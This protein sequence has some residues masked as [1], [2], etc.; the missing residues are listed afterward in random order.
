MGKAL[1]E[2][3]D[4]DFPKLAQDSV[5]DRAS[6]GVEET[7]KRGRYGRLTQLV[8]ETLEVT[9]EAYKGFKAKPMQRRTKAK[10]ECEQS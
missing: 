1:L 9:D 6:F 2:S 7:A 5:E 10:A 3:K 8:S 4:P